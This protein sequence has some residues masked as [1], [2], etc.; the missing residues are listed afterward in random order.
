MDRNTLEALLRQ[1]EGTWL[2]FK[3]E[4]YRF[5]HA[6]D[7]D[8]GELLKDMLAFANSW[9]VSPAYILIG[10]E[11]V[12]GGPSRIVGVQE[13][14]QDADLHQ[15][16]NN[17]TQRR[18]DF[19]YE[20]FQTESGTIG[21][22]EIP[23]QERPIYL[24]ANYGKLKRNQVYI[25]DGS[26]TKVATPDEIKQMGIEHSTANVS[27]LQLEWVD[28][29]TR[30]MLP[31]PHDVNTAALCPPGFLIKFQMAIG[32]GQPRSDS[33]ARHLYIS[34][35]RIYELARFQAGSVPLGLCLKNHSGTPA[36][37]VRFV[38][39]IQSEQDV[40]IV[41]NSDLPTPGQLDVHPYIDDAHPFVHRYGLG[42]QITLD[43]G[44]VR[45]HD[46]AYTSEPIWIYSGH[47]QTVR[48]AGELRADNVPDPIPCSVE[49]RFQ[50]EM[51]QMTM[52]HL[53]PL[54]TRRPRL[55]DNEEGGIE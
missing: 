7:D 35:H 28:V 5:T 31:S 40:D 45:P 11:E 49:L 22:I 37:R 1:P 55:P 24:V 21:V 54:L 12:Q 36:R 51:H 8:K 13:H 26:S 46:E 30:S 3:Q 18:M 42:W 33:P 41:V 52:G 27:Q 10:V 38:G 53:R 17:K 47:S 43:F 32:N 16:V 15:F 23:Q 20:R 19:V 4:Q 48:L 9:R 50:V 44:D 25:R 2:D 14:L 6:S 29:L 39:V 34:N